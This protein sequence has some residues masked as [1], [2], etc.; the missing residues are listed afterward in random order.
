MTPPPAAQPR[1][2]VRTRERY[3]AVQA[4]LAD[5]SSLAGICRTL[6]LDRKTVQRFARAA[7][8]DELLVKATGRSSL[9][10]AFTPYL[11][12][13]WAEGVTDAA[14]LTSEIAAMGYR[15]SDQT[16]RRYL[17]PFRGL[18]TPPPPPPKVPKPRT[19]TGW[20]LRRPESLEEDERQ[21]LKEV[22]ARCEH[23][24]RL[25]E[26]VKDFAVMMTKRQDRRLED[27]LARVEVDDLAE[28]HSFAAGIR[29]DQAA[30]TAGLTLPYSS[31]AVEG[32]V[33]RLKMLKRQ[34]Y[35]RARLDLL[36]K[37]VLLAA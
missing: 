7:S 10:D 33:N 32:S 11:H 16:V 21:Q 2:V 8:V 31:G 36:R 14:Q 34:M 1:L 37:R 25:A 27:W 15:G 9:L 6:E 13:R 3:A 22:R 18:L 29:R 4:L 26:H 35:G 24:D 12:Q 17:H 20:L 5:G 23:L 28:L 30:V 19:V